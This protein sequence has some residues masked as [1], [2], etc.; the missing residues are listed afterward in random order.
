M[1]ANPAS[2]AVFHLKRRVIALFFLKQSNC[3]GLQ[4]RANAVY[5][6]QKA[7]EVEVWK[8]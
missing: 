2:S 8:M 5:A 3:C 6:E 7:S 4:S 1:T